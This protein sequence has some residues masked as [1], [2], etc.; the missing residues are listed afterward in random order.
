MYSAADLINFVQRRLR[1][2]AWRGSHPPGEFPPGWEDWFA[3]MDERGGTVT[4]ASADSLTAV[5]LQRPPS[6]P[7]ARVASMTQWQAFSA[8]WRQQWHEAESDERGLRWAAG[9]VSAAVHLV[10]GLA[11]L[12][13]LY[14]PA[15]PASAPPQGEMVVQVEYTGT[16]T[17]E[18]IGGGPP[19]QP[20]A[21]V[22]PGRATEQAV[23]PPPPAAP[24]DEAPAGTAA[25]E[26]AP[27]EPSPAPLPPMPAPAPVESLATPL[28]ITPVLPELQVPDVP[29]PEVVPREIPVPT[30]PAQAQQPL[31][32]SEPAPDATEV[33]LLPP[34]TPRVVEPEMAA[35]ELSA[36]MP[37]VRRRD[38]PQ[39]EVPE[40]EPVFQPPS[41]P[42][43]PIVQPDPAPL[44]LPQRVPEVA[45]RE[46]PAPLSRAIERDLPVRPIE[47]PE[48]RATVPEVRR[49]MI[50]APPSVEPSQ[51]GPAPAAPSTAGTSP[52]ESLP[53][54]AAPAA[55]PAPATDQA[56]DELVGSGPRPAPTA[57]G[58]ATPARADDWGDAARDQPG[59]QRGDEPG[60]Y[61]SDGSVRLAD[62]PGS[63]SPGM[64]PGTVTDEITDLDRSGTWLKRPP[65]DY[66]PT[67]FDQYWRPNETLLAEWVRR[68]M[69]EVAI[70]IPGT[71]KTILCVVSMLGLGGSCGISDPNLNEQPATARPPPDI[72]FK[73]EL[74][75]DNGSIRPGG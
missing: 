63:A 49:A 40:P 1:L 7:P 67:A 68:G 11:L 61:N 26:P 20:D 3:S 4:G 48:L 69:R 5:L 17:P 53:A 51:A 9:T 34:P 73:P 37:I 39:P 8:M 19:P 25:V 28:E 6:V 10:L 15:P 2:T 57:G 35:P 38:V 46:V 70:P 56:R 58:W 59:A 50:P 22:D 29:V 41:A 12:W 21:P 44:A 65:I 30:P 31:A 60:I 24:A 18:E 45:V 42:L 64:P 32:V 43:R 52:A 74:Q 47:A 14:L 55:S 13:L 62:T 27:V 72:P 54:E 71:N 75:E 36:P 33:F 16:G 66:E 23:V